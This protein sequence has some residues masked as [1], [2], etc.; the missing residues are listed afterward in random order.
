MIPT[1]LRALLATALP[2][3][4]FACGGQ[5]EAKTE[6][7]LGCSS[8]PML[9]ERYAQLHINA[10][11]IDDT[12]LTAAAKVFVG[13]VDSSKSLLTLDESNRLE[14]R[15][16]AFYKDV[17]ESRCGGLRELLDFQV[18]RQEEIE[19]FVKKALGAKGFA[20]DKTLSLDLDAEK[21]PWPATTKARDELRRALIH[22]QLANY[23]AGGKTLDEAK[24]KL[25]KRYELITRRV[26]E[27]TEGDLYA[28]L[29]DAFAEAFDPHT[30]YFSAEDLEDF[31]ISMQLSLEGIGAV[32]RQRDGFTTINEIVKGGAADRE[33]QLKANDRI[34]AV[35][36][37][38]DGEPV[39]VVDMS[40]RDVV[41]L[42]RGKKGTKVRLTVMRDAETTER[43]S[44]TIVRDK[45]DLD[46]QA[47]KLRWETVERAGRKLKLAIIELPSFYG[48][49][50]EGAHDATDDMAKLLAEARDGQADGLVVDL[51]TNTGGLLQGA[52][53]IAGLFF[54]TGG[55]VRVEGTSERAQT[56]ED[57]DPRVQ[58]SGPLVVLTSHLSASASEIFAG[59]I[60][61][62]RRGV[63]VGD[64]HTFGKGSVQNVVNLPQGLGALKVTT[65]LFFRPNGQSTQLKGVDADI[66]VPSPFDGEHFGE[67]AHKNALAHR[68]TVTFA[69]PE[70]QGRGADAWT[71]VTDSLI[72]RLA[73]LSKK[74]V[75]ASADFAK[76][77]EDLAK[78]KKDG[79]VVKIAELLDGKNDRDEDGF[80][81]EDDKAKKDDEKLTPQ[82]TEA[83]QVLADLIEASSAIAKPVK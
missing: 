73:A 36:Q 59:A 1:A 76:V 53:E 27:Q 22:F 58:W 5:A 48:G 65:A 6:N 29:L 17:Q 7:L 70:A 79:D 45:I 54:K 81:K 11:S 50:D 2:V 47:A 16:R 38:D 12:L 78:A 71:P 8:M 23:V 3:A 25:I 19:A 9:M 57:V 75:D 24:Q 55:V 4:T 44:V 34:I 42:I 72:A 52:V 13:R 56:L 74:R 51:S 80:K 49:A 77:K 68:S 67:K 82:A 14:A 28:S 46:E 20:L 63:I 18:S 61:D 43:F 35:A 62:Y 39:D 15:V 26:K 60:K 40:L 30:S 32:L 69:S 41:R 83:V 10:P 31:R 33:G 21:R 37:G 66:L 64:D